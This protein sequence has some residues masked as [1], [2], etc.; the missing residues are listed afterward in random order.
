M[1]L[2]KTTP[3]RYTLDEAICTEVRSEVARVRASLAE[4]GEKTGLARMTLSRKINGKSTF[5][6]GELAAVAT[7]LGT[8]AGTI[9]ARAERMDAEQDSSTLAGETSVPTTA[10]VGGSPASPSSVERLL[11]HE[12]A[13]DSCWSLEDAARHTAGATDETDPAAARPAALA[14]A[15]GQEV[16]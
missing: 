8:T 2:M 4:I 11:E 9:L 14:A 7:A 5:S 3:F 6:V 13:C 10:V 12:Q 15:T 1:C 16:A